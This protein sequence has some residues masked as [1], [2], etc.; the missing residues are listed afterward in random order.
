MNNVSMAFMAVFAGAVCTGCAFNPETMPIT[1]RDQAVYVDAG[2]PKRNAEKKARVA[3][4]ASVGE[5]RQY[6]II[7]DSLSSSL[8]D[9]LAQFAF[10]DLLDKSNKDALLKEK[11]SSA[12]DPTEVDFKDLEADFVVVAKIASL[13]TRSFGSSVSIDVQFDFAWISTGDSQRVIMKKSIKPSLRNANA[14]V[15]GD[16]FDVLRRAAEKASQEFSEM[17]SSKYAPPARVLQTRGNG[18]AARIS[19]GQDYGLRVGMEVEFYEIV[20]NSALGGDARDNSIIARGEVKSVEAKA[21]WVK[22]SDFEQ[23][24]VRKGVYVRIPEQKESFGSKLME[25]S[26]VN[27]LL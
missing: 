4:Q 6:K 2:A 25:T 1:Q 22:V 13:T 10:F 19:I 20:D 16:V 5:Y 17:I 26:G 23:V 27:S 21:A 7:A 9:R 12:A 18:A 8:R 14:Q 11:M 3:V 24:N 15:E